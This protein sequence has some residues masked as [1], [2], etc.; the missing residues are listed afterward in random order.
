MQNGILIIKA[1]FIYCIGLVTTLGFWSI[2]WYLFLW[3][4]IAQK[5]VKKTKSVIEMFSNFIAEVLEN[6]LRAHPVS[7]TKEWA[8]ETNRSMTIVKPEQNV[9]IY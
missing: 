8:F 5:V 1:D 9:M 7:T 6:S 4:S 2:I 3:P